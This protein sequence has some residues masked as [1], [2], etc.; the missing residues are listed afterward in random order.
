M[1]ILIEQDKKNINWVPLAGFFVIVVAVITTIYYLFIVNPGKIENI[2]SP[3]L[4]PLSEI[5]KINFNPD[6]LIS[7]QQFK[8]LTSQVTFTPAAPDS[9]GKSNLFLP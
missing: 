6:Q 4:K 3:E 7:N 2:I 8:A 5:G 9:L 1:A